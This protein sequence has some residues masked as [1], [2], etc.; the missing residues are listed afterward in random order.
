MIF[1]EED[2]DE[3]KPKKLEIKKHTQKPIKVS[4]IILL[5]SF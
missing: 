1:H 2:L 4:F 5:F 3:K